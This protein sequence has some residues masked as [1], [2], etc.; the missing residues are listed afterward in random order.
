MDQYNDHETKKV[1]DNIGEGECFYSDHSRSMQ[2]ACSYCVDVFNQLI[3]QQSNISSSSS[4]SLSS[5]L[6]DLSGT[7]NVVRSKSNNH[8]DRRNDAARKFWSDIDTLDSESKPA[9]FERLVAKLVHING[10]DNDDIDAD[11][12]VIDRKQVRSFQENYQDLNVPCLIT[13]LDHSSHFNFV[14]QN[15]R[16]TNH[17]SSDSKINRNWFLQE[18]GNSF[19]VPLRYTHQNAI[20]NN[21]T[22]LDKDGRA[23]ESQ[24]LEVSMK[25]WLQLLEQ[26]TLPLEDQSHSSI[27]NTLE[28]VSTVRS[29]SV[30]Y[31]LKDWHLQQI[32]TLSNKGNGNCSL[33]SCPDF[34]GGD[35]LNPFL[36]K[37]TTGDYRFCYW[38][39]TGS[40]TSQHSDVLHSFS[41]S[42]NVV[43]S[44][45]WKFY[46]SNTSIDD[47]DNNDNRNS[48]DIKDQN[49]T[50]NNNNQNKTFTVQ[51]S[52]GEI[53]FVPATWQH[54]VVNTEESISINHNWITPSSLDLTWDCL[55]VEMRAVQ[56]EL[57]DW[58][59]NENLDQN[60]EAC[61]NMLR[62][63][64][65]LDVTAFI[66]MTLVRVLD[67]ITELLL[68]SNEHQERLIFDLFRLTTVLRKVFTEEL[69]LVQLRKRLKAVLQIDHMVEKVE[70]IT[71]CVIKSFL[72]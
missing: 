29:K 32:H 62:G 8:R 14:N 43:G 38:G 40:Y 17:N 21:D 33:Y 34:F 37:F 5:W 7:N 26:K 22:E 55:R 12:I 44:K 30:T 24:T 64:I 69:D 19:I 63:C 51:Q 39:P 66:M 23:R 45:E 9:V 11:N 56:K 6:L 70:M 54:Q 50:I 13:G 68:Q 47:D 42:Y 52:T 31:Y 15:W 41:W 3:E 36:K 57:G 28:Q 10:D 48:N 25:E 65:G 2:K 71:M 72:P 4:S 46:Q 27:N 1:D 60:M 18:F 49:S 35:L 20:N 67:I 59:Q 58:T 16:N 61:E 53:M